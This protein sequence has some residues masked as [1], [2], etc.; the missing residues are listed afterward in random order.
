MK[1]DEKIIIQNSVFDIIENNRGE[2]HCIESVKIIIIK[3][4]KIP[5][6]LQFI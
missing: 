3:L 1:M 6:N 2:L 4:T 5:S